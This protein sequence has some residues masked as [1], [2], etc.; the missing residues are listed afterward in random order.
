MILGG[1]C[2]L[3][4]VPCRKKPGLDKIRIMDYINYVCPFL[5]QQV[6]SK[7]FTL[8]RENRKNGQN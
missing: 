4:N 6:I 3:R 1:L 8:Y 5:F 7:S 2:L